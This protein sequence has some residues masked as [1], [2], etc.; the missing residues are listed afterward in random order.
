M[1]NNYFVYFPL[2]EFDMS[3][4][5]LMNKRKYLLKKG[6]PVIVT[7]SNSKCGTISVA[8]SLKKLK[9]KGRLIPSY[10]MHTFIEDEG[11]FKNNNLISS[12]E[13]TKVFNDKREYFRWKF[14]FGVREPIIR[15]ISNYYQESFNSGNY[16]FTIEYLNSFLGGLDFLYEQYK[17]KLGIDLYEYKFNKKMGYSIIT[18]GNISVL[19]YRLDKL[20]DIFTKAIGEFLGFKNIKLIKS[21][22]TDK[23]NIYYEGISIG[24]YYKKTK[25]NFKLPKGYLEKVYNNKSVTNFFTDDE[26]EGFINKW[27]ED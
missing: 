24:D 15:C 4:K 10:H 8:G 18:K 6:D 12:Y 25:N 1:D 14:I 11:E 22:E 19:I 23:K 9:Y 26:I 3:N 5:F 16:S 27:R 2:T 7:L 13:L 17:N 20:D 21:H